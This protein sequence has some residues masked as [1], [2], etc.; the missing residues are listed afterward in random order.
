MNVEFV[1]FQASDGVEL[2]GWYT[3]AKTDSV[4]IHVH[5]MSGNGYENYFLDN[6]H[7]IYL[8]KGISVFTFDTRGRGVISSFRQ[9]KT[10]LEDIKLGGSCYEVFEESIHDIQG[11]IDFLKS[12][13][14]NKFIL[15]GHSLGSSKVVNYLT[16]VKEMNILCCILLAPTDMIGWA[17]ADPNHEKYLKK[18][19]YLVSE[20]RN[21]EFVDSMCW[22]DKTPLSARTYLSMSKRGT[23]VDIYNEIKGK[24]RLGRVE[25]PMLIVYGSN[26]IGIEKIDGTIEKWLDR[27][28]K[29]KNSNTSIKIIEGASHSFKDHEEELSEIINIFLKEMSKN[30]MN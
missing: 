18:A 30:E 12:K 9:N 21:K 27:V 7:K 19:E 23:A 29:I 28:L 22:L 2:Q 13:G 11:A 6:L 5:G 8:E 14:K 10:G 25:I 16:S 26:D 17:S 3:E 15:Q 1:R 20:K 4:V 24:A